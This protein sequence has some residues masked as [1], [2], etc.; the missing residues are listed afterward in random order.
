MMP[1][2][3]VIGTLLARPPLEREAYA[4]HLAKLFIRI[5][6]PDYE[7]DFERLRERAL[8]MYD[9]CYYPT[10]SA[11]QLMALMA[12]GDR[13][14]ELGTISCPTLVI[15]GEADKL[16]PAGA[17]RTVARAIPAARYELIE[18]M[19]HDLPVELWPRFTRSIV[20][21]AVR[22]KPVSELA[23][24]APGAIGS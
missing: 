8:V 5:G 2:P 4:A 20:D 11:R 19:G 17:G 15:H 23:R 12:S 6:S 22:A 3:S 10:G 7:P 21:N 13:T 18:G 16:M 1:R 9:R 24:A 14:A